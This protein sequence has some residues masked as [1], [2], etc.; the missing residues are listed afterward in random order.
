MRKLQ[1]QENSEMSR[2]G[3]L[4]TAGITAA[5]ISTGYKDLLASASVAKAGGRQKAVA[6]V[7]GAFVYPPTE[8]LREVGYYSWPGSTFDAEGRQKQYM[9][10]IKQIEQELGM[11][12]LMDAKPLDDEGDV[13]RFID[14]VKRSKPD[15]LLLIPF[16]KGHWGHVKRVVAETG[17][18]SVV[19]A[20]LGILLVGHINELRR[21][22]GVYLINS[23]DN[24][25]ALESGMRMIRTGRWMKEARIVNID[26]SELK[27]TRVPAI[28]TEVRTIPHQQF[29]DE[30]ARTQVT[31]AVKKLADAYLKNA[32]EIVEPSKDDILE[33]AKCYFALK[34]IIEAEQGD[35][36]MMNCL[37]G[38]KRPHK[39]VPPC[40]GFMSLRDEGIAAG[41]QADLNPTLTLMLVQKLFDK[42]GFQQNAS[43]ETEKNHYFGAHCTSASKMNG[44]N[45]PSEPYILMC[46]AEAGWG[47]VPRVLFSAGQEVTMAQYIS[48]EKPQMLIYSGEVIGCPPIP[49]TGGCRT[50]IEMTINEVDDVCD[51]KGMHQIIFYGNWAKQLRAYCQLYG[52]EADPKT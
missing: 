31:D 39:H 35:A 44:P 48:G 24:F 40:M 46:H 45:T 32:K 11:R 50:N 9:S 19:L 18:P 30:Y 41:C 4:Q 28:G 34:Q 3:F 43:M 5:G 23:L 51:V 33:A 37:P 15:G 1:S 10:K 14:E 16:K 6:T 17:T 29:Y 13:T 52:I 36:V 21:K 7:R 27:V 49:P 22:L 42:P 47:C 12:I 20:T 38:L 8:R 25:A 26:G 2:R